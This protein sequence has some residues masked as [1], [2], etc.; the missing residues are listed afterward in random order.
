MAEEEYDFS[1]LDSLIDPGRKKKEVSALPRSTWRSGGL[2]DQD[3]PQTSV[4]E[5]RDVTSSPPVSK[6]QSTAN[7]N[8][9]AA[10]WIAK[11]LGPE[12]VGTH[13]STIQET[14]NAG[15]IGDKTL[16]P[17]I[18]TRTVKSPREAFLAQEGMIDN[19][20]KFDQGAMAQAYARETAQEKAEAIAK[21]REGIAKQIMSTLPTP[22]APAINTSKE[23]PTNMP[24]K[25]AY[26]DSYHNLPPEARGLLQP[27]LKKAYYE[28]VDR[29]F[30]S[31][32]M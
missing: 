17:Q 1:F 12:F 6:M 30:K 27:G 11:H 18:G 15:R 9:M 26:W 7:I 8:P 19:S 20:G 10:K 23:P 13:Y 3:T 16:G 29:A 2:T 24:N 28:I 25:K 5:G 14:I 22:S 21:Q 32:G 4:L 31:A